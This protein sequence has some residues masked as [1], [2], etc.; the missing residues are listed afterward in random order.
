MQNGKKSPPKKSLTQCHEQVK[1]CMK[2]A[3]AGVP[4]KEELNLSI[5]P[6][7]KTMQGNFELHNQLKGTDASYCE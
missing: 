7:F 6:R 1:L 2:Q 5:R 3:T 4:N